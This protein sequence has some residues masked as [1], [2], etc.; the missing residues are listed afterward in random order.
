VP[1]FARGQRVPAPS[2]VRSSC[3]RSSR[4]RATLA[5]GAASV[6]CARQGSSVTTSL[7]PVFVLVDVNV[8]RAPT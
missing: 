3:A 5:A 4:V 8:P 6:A 1:R 2:L 7:E